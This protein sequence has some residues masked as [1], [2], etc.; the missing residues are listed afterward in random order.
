MHS[1]LSSNLK[2]TFPSL[3]PNHAHTP[4]M[5]Y[6]CTKASQTTI[7]DPEAPISQAPHTCTHSSLNCCWIVVE[8]HTCTCSSAVPV[9]HS[10][11]QIGRVCVTGYTNPASSQTQRALCSM[12]GVPVPS[13]KHQAFEYLLSV[14]YL[15]CAQLPA[16][17]LKRHFADRLCTGF[18]ARLAQTCVTRQHR[19]YN[20]SASSTV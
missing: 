2:H 12:V 6:A 15:I 9:S 19:G 8:L 4:V 20:Y 18:S 13:S 7:E 1:M 17:K 5:C 16:L 10:F 11:F 14:T 3:Y